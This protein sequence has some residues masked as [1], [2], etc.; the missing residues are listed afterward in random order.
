LEHPSS[1]QKIFDDPLKHENTSLPLP[2]IDF[3]NTSAEPS[4]EVIDSRRTV[5]CSG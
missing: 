1:I 3:V 4:N 5:F 2:A